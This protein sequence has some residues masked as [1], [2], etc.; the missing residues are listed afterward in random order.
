[1]LN[2]L[3]AIFFFFFEKGVLHLYIKLGSVQSEYA[4]T[5]PIC[6]CIEVLR[7]SF[8]SSNE[9]DEVFNT[10]STFFFTE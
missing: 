9:V 10:L 6:F 8:L 2:K 3:S 7:L 1:M 4:L 5:D